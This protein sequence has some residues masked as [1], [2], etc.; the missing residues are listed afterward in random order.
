MPI[1]GTR[2]SLQMLAVA[3]AT[4]CLR[5]NRVPSPGLLAHAGLPLTL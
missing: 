4:A 3:R 5:L 2:L 1:E